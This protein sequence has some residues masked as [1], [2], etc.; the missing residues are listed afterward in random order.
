M[1][2][3]GAKRHPVRGVVRER[4]C[5]GVRRV[6]VAIAR[7]V[8]GRCAFV[9]RRGRLAKTRSCRRP[10]LLAA[11]GTR[12]FGLRRSV[13]LRRGRYVVR[14]YAIDRAANHERAGRAV[15]VRIR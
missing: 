6:Y 2:D 10:A 9:S 3:G 4:G 7:R 1:V 5:A 14:G 11:R 15:T 12:T 13:R 8:H